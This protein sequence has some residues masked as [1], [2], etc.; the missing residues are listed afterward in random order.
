MVGK[1]VRFGRR[2]LCSYVLPFLVYHSDWNDEMEV[3]VLS[4]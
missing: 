4:R 1:G 3:D 2:K